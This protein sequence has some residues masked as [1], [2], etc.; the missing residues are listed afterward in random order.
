MG[1]LCAGDLGARA[2]L[3]GS[4]AVADDIEAVRATLG[5][6]KL[7]LWGD[8]YGTFLMPVYAARHPEHVRSIVLDGAFPIASD[9]WGRDVL[10]A[11]GASSGSSAGARTL[12]GPP[13]A[14]RRRATRPAPAAAPADVHRAQPA[15]AA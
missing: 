3:Y 14:R 13:R 1:T 10:R 6:E 2:G 5:A 4:A 7:D 9:P 12:L 11:S 15:R 8:S